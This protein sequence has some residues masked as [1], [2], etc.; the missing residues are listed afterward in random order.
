MEEYQSDR[1]KRYAKRCAM[2]TLINQKPKKRKTLICTRNAFMCIGN[3]IPSDILDWICHCL[4]PNDIINVS[5]TCKYYHRLITR[6]VSL[7]MW[8]AMGTFLKEIYYSPIFNMDRMRIHHGSWFYQLC[9]RL[10]PTCLTYCSLVDV[11]NNNG[12]KSILFGSRALNKVEKL[13]FV[14]ISSPK[15]FQREVVSH[16]NIFKRNLN[17]KFYFANWERIIFTRDRL[18]RFFLAGGSVVKSIVGSNM[19]D[20]ANTSDLDFFVYSF[21]RTNDQ[22]FR[23]AI[24]ARFDLLVQDFVI[25]YDQRSLWYFDRGE[26]RKIYNVFI[27][28]SGKDSQIRQSC[29]IL[30]SRD[31]SRIR[32][33]GMPI[34]VNEQKNEI[35]M[36]IQEEGFWTKMQ[37]IYEEYRF[38]KTHHAREFAILQDFDLD[39]CQ[40]GYNGKQ[41]VCTPSF[42]ESINTGTFMCYEVIKS[43]IR[44][45]KSNSDRL[46]KYYMRGFDLLLPKQLIAELKTKRDINYILLAIEKRRLWEEENP[47]ESRYKGYRRLW[48][49]MRIR[50]YK[51]RELRGKNSA[52]LYTRNLVKDLYTGNLKEFIVS[53]IH[54]WSKIVDL[55]YAGVSQV[56]S[57]RR[58]CRFK[59]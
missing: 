8:P 28:F 25:V 4:N 56:S 44:S 9:A 5:F 30:R 3:N 26:V 17:T 54:K 33:D 32:Y 31:D 16:I 58:Y 29:S 6:S 46:R 21:G 51:E 10:I 14:Q 1:T 2:K 53:Y 19:H 34:I 7:S 24:E 12:K 48:H 39:C 50:L 59:F 52:D 18:F 36:V 49:Q 37:F 20:E 41:V 35:I 27:N 22:R 40:I 45:R 15:S 42:V 38:E 43:V 47:Q 13:T 11:F 57:N 55:N 23:R